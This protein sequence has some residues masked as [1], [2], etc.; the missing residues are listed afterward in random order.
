MK[1]PNP[2]AVTCDPAA[3]ADDLLPGQA[4]CGNC[5]F[6]VADGCTFDGTP[7]RGSGRCEMPGFVGYGRHVDSYRRCAAGQFKNYR[8]AD[9]VIPF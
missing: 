4:R 3:P 1:T 7:Y 8:D 9:D 5:R 6:F 2:P